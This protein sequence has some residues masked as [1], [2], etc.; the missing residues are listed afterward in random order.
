MFP[1]ASKFSSKNNKFI[2][3]VLLENNVAKFA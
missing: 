1:A 2:N 3:I